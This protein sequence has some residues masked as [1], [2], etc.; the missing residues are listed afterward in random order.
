[1]LGGKHREATVPIFVVEYL[2]RASASAVEELQ[3]DADNLAHAERLAMANYASIC[4]AMPE[5][6]IRGFRIL[7]ADMDV[8]RPFKPENF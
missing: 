1:M 7:D 3:V 6:R 5:T 4:E 8:V 2:N